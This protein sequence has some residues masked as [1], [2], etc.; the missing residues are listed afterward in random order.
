MRQTV[1]FRNILIYYLNSMVRRTSIDP[2]ASNI[3]VVSGHLHWLLLMDLRQWYATGLL[4]RFVFLQSVVGGG[5]RGRVFDFA[6]CSFMFSVGGKILGLE[7]N[8]Q[9][10]FRIDL[11]EPDPWST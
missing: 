6:A 8:S 2:L 9:L 5:L 10:A 11:L 7:V 1:I 4:S 3:D